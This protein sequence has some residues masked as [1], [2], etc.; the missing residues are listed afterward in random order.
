MI[1]WECSGPTPALHEICTTILP[2]PKNVGLRCVLPVSLI[3]VKKLDG[4][5]RKFWVLVPYC[6]DR[7]Y[8]HFL[9]S[10]SLVRAWWS[11]CQLHLWCSCGCFVWQ[12]AFAAE[13]RWKMQQQQEQQQRDAPVEKLSRLNSVLDSNEFSFGYIV[14]PIFSTFVFYWRKVDILYGR[15]RSDYKE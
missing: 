5:G 15:H 10:R 7:C 3:L 12:R 8:Y 11:S 9:G 13:Q 4:L 6:I 1:S 14:F 2:L